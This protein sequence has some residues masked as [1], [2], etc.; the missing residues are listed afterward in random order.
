MAQIKLDVTVNTQNAKTQIKALNGQ[1]KSLSNSLSSIKPN[2]EL[3]AQLNA[4]AKAL[5]ASAKSMNAQ[6]KADKEH[7]KQLKAVAAEGKKATKTT[8]DRTKAIK[9]GTVANEKHT[10]SILSMAKGFL[11]WQVSATIVMQSINLV[12]NGLESLNETLVNTEKATIEITRILNEDIADQEVASKLYDL[13][14]QYG[15][16]FENVSE[17]ATNFARAG[18]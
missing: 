5:N 14:E 3:T 10:Q 9:D 7:A 8:K 18:V 16:T 1:I 17:I 12:R 4:L 11:S 13:A 6:T 15:Q 2:K